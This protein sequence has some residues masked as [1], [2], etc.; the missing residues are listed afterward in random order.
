MIMS[1]L[2]HKIITPPSPKKT[3]KKKKTHKIN[4]EGQETA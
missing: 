3:E 4:D 2:E 1:I